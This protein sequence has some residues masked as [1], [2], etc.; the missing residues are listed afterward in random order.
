MTTYLVVMDD[1]HLAEHCLHSLCSLEIN[2]FEHSSLFA[3]LVLE[4]SNR[5]PEYGSLQDARD[6]SVPSTAST[7]LLSFLDQAQVVSLVRDVIDASSEAQTDQDLKYR[8]GR[9]RDRLYETNVY[10]N[11]N[12]VWMRPYIYPLNAIDHYSQAAQRLYMSATVGEPGDLSRR[13]GTKPI[14]KMSIPPE[15]SDVTS[16]RRFIV[17]D[18]SG[19]KDISSRL[20]AAIVAALRLSPK[21]LWLCSSDSEARQL[22]AIVSGWLPKNGFTDH[23]TWRLS[24]LGDEI[25]QFKAAKSGHLFVAGRFDGMDF[26]ADECR[27]VVLTTLPRAINAQEEFVSAYL[28]D[29]GFMRRRL[30]Q[31]IIQALGRCNRAADDY[32][33]YVLA[34][35]RFATHLGRDQN[36]QGFPANMVAEIDMALD[37][38]ED[39]ETALVDKI[40]RFLKG[41]FTGY[42]RELADY[43]AGVHRREAVATSPADTTKHE[44]LGW[45]SLFHSKNYR[46]ASEQFEKCWDVALAANE[47]EICALYGWQWAKALYLRSLQQETGMREKALGVLDRSINRGGASSWFNRLRSSLN[48]ERGNAAQRISLGEDY[49]EAVFR[50]FDEYLDIHGAS[51]KRF[52]KAISQLSARLR[53]SAHDGYSKGLEDLGGLLGFGATRPTYNAA[54]DCRWRGVFGSTREVFTFEAKIEHLASSEITASFVGQAHN[55]LSRAQ[56]E[57]GGLGYAVRGA[58]VTPL[59]EIASDAVASIGP[60][61][62]IDSAAMADLADLVIAILSQYHD[63]WSDVLPNGK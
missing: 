32:G 58:I 9:M 31:R 50:A 1:A 38:A 27:L 43:R 33:V 16:G 11:A 23:P 44:V 29:S 34:D 15:Y 8:W 37:G 53:S 54:T 17:V 51:G 49:V 21:S 14:S 39:N 30:N 48:R 5:F 22:Q 46:V 62:V 35:R 20:A 42:D 56:N 26:K 13:L 55:Q 10:V 59:T 28:R 4:L 63:R 6:P 25:D 3:K 47:H 7:E 45:T 52:H 2:R 18:T 57:F 12:T 60:I 36:L 40:S 24:P 61:K 41:D 19:E